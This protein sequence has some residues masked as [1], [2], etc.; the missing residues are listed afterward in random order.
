MISGRMIQIMKYLEGKEESSYRELSQELDISER[1]IRYDIDNINAHLKW[2]NL[3]VI[4][5]KSKGKLLVPPAL[6]YLDLNEEEDY[7]FTPSERIN[8]LTFFIFFN[9]KNLNLEKLS[10]IFMVSR[11]TLKN[12]LSI[13][14]CDL[15]DKKFVLEYKR[16]FSIIG[17][18]K[19]LLNERVNL[20][21]DYIDYMDSEEENVDNYH[22]F[23]LKE[24]KTSLKD[25]NVHKIKRWTKDLLNQMGWVLNDDSYHWYLANILVFTWYIKNN[26]DSPLHD[27]NYMMSTFDRKIIAEL[28]EIIDYKLNRKEIDI[29]ISFIFY[30]SKYASLNEELDLLTTEK[31][32]DMLIDTMAVRLNVPF[33]QDSILYKGLLNHVAPLLQRIRSNVQIYDNSF[34]ILPREYGYLKE[35]LEMSIKEIELLRE[36][37]NENEITLL[38]IYFL[39][40][41]QRNSTVQYKNVLLVCGLGYGAIAMIKDKLNSTYQ[42]NY[43][44]TIPR[45]IVKEFNNWDN[46]DLIITTAKLKMNTEKP[47]V[48]INPVMDEADFLK[49]ENAGL[50]KKNILTNY[51]T[52]NRRLDF[53]DGNTKKKVMDVIKEELG[54]LEVRIPERKLNLSDLI[55]IDAIKIIDTS[56]DW[57]EA[58]NISGKILSDTGSIDKEYTES[59]I[60][61]QEKLGFYSVKDQEFALLHGNNSNL[62]KIS[63]VSLLICKKTIS[64]GEKGVKIIFMLASKDKK[65]QIPAVIGLTKMTY[66]TDFITQLE[67]AESPLEADQIIREYEKR[68][69]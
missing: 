26:L 2:K 8:I 34:N 9:I 61:I 60:A 10:E 16:G 35:E 27:A 39:A 50:Q 11:T 25:I 41:M 37:D 56:I 40:S 42:I 43:V 6:T 19:N 21:R 29:L 67:K 58:V 36:I 31:T 18:E 12:D 44:D 57:K 48:Q 64:F 33:N 1:K 32:V 66:H 24:I 63:S 15:K 52:I 28:E 45:Y 51:L 4:S 5:K 22:Q 17:N 20:F 23:I 14:E 54:Y 47:I 30:T 68:I 3:D 7:F 69:Q 49:L 59:I 13:I 55:G 65:E 46:V 38:T 53:L 62:V